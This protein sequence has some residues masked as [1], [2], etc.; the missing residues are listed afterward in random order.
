M[1]FETNEFY[2]K[3]SEE[4]AESFADMPEAI[5]S[6]LEIAERCDTTIALKQQL[7][8]R[9]DSPDGLTEE[10]TSAQLVR[11]ACASVTAIDARAGQ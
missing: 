9:F 3:S 8:P 2:L 11:A 7:I 5:A 4:M 1:S 6:T 10:P